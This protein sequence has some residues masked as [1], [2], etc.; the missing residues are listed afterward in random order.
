M[1][2]QELSSL[3]KTIADLTARLDKYEHDYKNHV[4][5]GIST[6]NV[7]DKDVIPGYRSGGSITMSTEG[8]IYKLGVTHK[9]KSLLFY[10]VASNT[11]LNERVFV[12]GS[13]HLG[14]SYYF[15]PDTTSTVKPGGPLQNFYQS[16]SCVALDGSTTKYAAASSGGAVTSAFN[17]IT[18]KALASE[19]HI[20]NAILTSSSDI[21]AR[22]T[23]IS[24]SNTE[25]QIELE[26][27]G[28]G[29]SVDGNWVVS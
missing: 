2:S 14:P 7:N 26:T 6:M 12:V 4:H 23:I 25:V 11:S 17:P 28:S 27:L 29:W 10:G 8:Q 3:K 19:G 15:Q 5:D 18:V 1:D 20:V 22:A 13:A 24:F 21:K 16:S 9:P